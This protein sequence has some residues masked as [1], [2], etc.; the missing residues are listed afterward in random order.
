MG[1]GIKTTILL[2]L[3]TVFIL[4]IGNLLG[5]RSGMIL[6]LFLAG[7]INLFSYWFSDKVVLKMYKAREV[8]ENEAPGLYN[9]V[10]E[11]ARNADLPM[12]KVYIIPQQA[13]NAFATG[14]NP[15]HAVVAVTE[16]IL[17]IMERDEIRGVLAHELAHVKNRDT[18]ISTIA[19]T[20]AG[21]VMILAN[22]ARWSVF[23]GGGDDDE[24]GLGI[25][26]LIIMSILAPIAAL[27]IQ[28]AISRSREYAADASGSRF[29]QH[30]EA[31]ANALEKI[32]NYSQKGQINADPATAHM[33]IVNP[34][35][36]QKLASLFS[37]HPPLEERIA[38][39]RGYGKSSGYGNKTG[40]RSKADEDRS[41]QKARA[42]WDKLSQ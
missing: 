13:P 41:R 27:L 34:L 9:I 1:N 4:W 5:G 14:R 3:L 7:G 37:T 15:D 23:F 39:L 29:S 20:L 35:S 17:N 36:G 33:F 16:G 31:L 8:T 38:R 6:A 32:G 40:S 22:I 30:P 2:T 10:Q 25:I 21:A 19:A 18:L 28:M 24:G 11:L 12:P 42:M 26:G